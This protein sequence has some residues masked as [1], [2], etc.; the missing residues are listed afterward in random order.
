MTI[1]SHW[2]AAASDDGIVGVYDSVTGA[3]RLILNP[4]NPVRTIRGSP[5]GSLLFCAHEGPSI[6]LWDIQTGGLI[7]TFV[8]KSKPKAIAISFAGCYLACGLPDG[9]VKVWEVANKREGGIVESG[10]SVVDLCWVE[11]EQL[12]AVGRVKSMEMWDAV[13][14]KVVRRFA[15]K[16]PIRGMV[17]SQALNKLAFLFASGA[18]STIAI[19]Q[20]TSGILS[21]YQSQQ[22][23]SCLAPFQ[24]TR[25][26]VCGT[27]APGLTVLDPRARTWRQVDHSV[28][29]ISIST[30]PDETVVANT[31]GSGIQLLDLDCGLPEGPTTSVDTFDE[32]RIIAAFSTT[33]RHTKLLGKTYME[34]VLTLPWTIGGTPT[35]CPTILCVSHQKRIVVYSAEMRGKWSLE[36]R[37]LDRLKRSVPEWTREVDGQPLAGEISPGRGQIV[38]FC[39]TRNSA[40]ILLLDTKTG[41]PMALLDVSDPFPPT[42][43]LEIEFESNGRFYSLHDTYRTSYDISAP[44]VSSIDF[45]GSITCRGQ[46]PL[47]ERPQRHYDLDDA[48]EWVICS[49]KRI[50]W[51]PPG[52]IRST[53]GGHCWVGNTLVMAGEDGILRKLTFQASRTILKSG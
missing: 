6:T 39:N 51:I 13:A 20:P 46:L 42:R 45:R 11:P 50:C 30:L 23:I 44:L 26:F 49:S 12:L 22:P 37:R 10:S 28:A 2:I 41:T 40:Q 32:D 52:Y 34:E 19:I 35:N 31:A 17:Y 29:M 25:A 48:H 18:G 53:E 43:P 14:G 27:V 24:A 9:S 1:F 5:D 38:I 15:V 47:V 3:P 36:L 8:L 16:L 7:H 4:Q 33:N 21:T